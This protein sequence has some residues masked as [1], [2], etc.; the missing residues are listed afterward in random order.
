MTEDSSHN[1]QKFLQRLQKARTAVVLTGAGVST[2]SGIPDFRGPGG[3]YSVLS[4]RTFEIEFFNASPVD[5]YKIAVDYIHTLADKQPN[6]TH[7]MLSE[8]ESVGLIRA[9]VTQNI[10]GLHQKAG[11][12]NIIEFHGNVVRFYCTRCEKEFDRD[13]VDPQIRKSS[14]PVCDNCSGLIR[15]GI[16][17]FG[18]PIPMNAL[19]DAQ[20]LAK[21]ADLFIVIGSSLEV[22]P[23][24]SLAA[25]AT[26]TGAELVIINRGP[27]ALDDVA[28]WRIET[29]LNLFSESILAILRA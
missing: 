26:R 20:L 5:Y 21:T 9:V 7:I 6:T 3:L 28:D 16:V 18:D 2:D 12:K 29:D 27:T 11:S 23:A 14:T 17:F 1:A 13:S 15:P 19:Y 10:D 22:N 24:A 4:P 8:L 25:D